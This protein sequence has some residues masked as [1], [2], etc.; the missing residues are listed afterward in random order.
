MKE[1]LISFRMPEEIEIEIEKLVAE[2][3]NDQGIK[4]VR[5]DEEID[6]KIIKDA[7]PD[8]IFSIY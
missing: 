3:C 1:R 5:F 8:L 6:L 4:N 2:Y 7:N